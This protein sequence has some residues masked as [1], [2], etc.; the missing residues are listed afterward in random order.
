MDKAGSL[1]DLRGGLEA[2]LP[3]LKPDDFA[4]AM[5]QALTAAQLAGRYDILNEAGRLNG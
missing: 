3:D 1:E 5:A 4:E 2:L